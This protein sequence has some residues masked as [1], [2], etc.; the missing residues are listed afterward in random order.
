M[1]LTCVCRAI[2]HDEKFFNN[3]VHPL[4]NH[5][6]FEHSV[7]PIFAFVL[8]C[9][10]LMCIPNR[11]I[12]MQYS[13]GSGA[14]FADLFWNVS[15]LKLLPT[16]GHNIMGNKGFLQ[17]RISSGDSSFLTVVLHRAG[18]LQYLPENR[19]FD[20]FC[21]HFTLTLHHSTI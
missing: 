11:R 4:A 21:L 16:T 9:A 5:Q 1:Y 18:V 15:Q 13:R 17:H 14:W 7:Q 2:K 12:H 6:Q 19:F 20:Q 3:S 8:Y 10:S